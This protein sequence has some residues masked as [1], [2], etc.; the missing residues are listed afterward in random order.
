MGTCFTDETYFL[1]LHTSDIIS[2]WITLHFIGSSDSQ[3]SGWP[4]AEIRTARPSHCVGRQEQELTNVS[5]WGINQN[6]HQRE[7]LTRQRDIPLRHTGYRWSGESLCHLSKDNSL[8]SIVSKKLSLVHI[9]NGLS[10]NSLSNLIWTVRKTIIKF[11]KHRYW[12]N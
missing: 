1:S 4:T 5:Q 7:H 11:Y 6:H 8:S 2:M 12:W 9:S 3:R 10:T